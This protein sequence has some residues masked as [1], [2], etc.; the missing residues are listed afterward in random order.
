MLWFFFSLPRAPSFIWRP[1]H[2]LDCSILEIHRTTSS[3]LSQLT[4][5]VQLKLKCK[6]W[7]HWCKFLTFMRS[8]CQKLLLNSVNCL[9]TSKLSNTMICRWPLKYW[10]AY[11]LFKSLHKKQKLGVLYWL[12][13]NNFQMPGNLLQINFFPANS[14][15][16]N[17]FVCHHWNNR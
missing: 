12:A 4:F 14:W 13:V 3:D 15:K 1:I 8:H 7:F 11:D 2:T 10:N 6:Y 9:L 17:V 5:R 16:Y